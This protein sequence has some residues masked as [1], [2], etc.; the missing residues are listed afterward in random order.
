MV[1]FAPVQ[2]NYIIAIF[3]QSGKLVEIWARSSWACVVRRNV[4]AVYID[5]IQTIQYIK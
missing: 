2:P 5:L 3:R 1:S 4:V